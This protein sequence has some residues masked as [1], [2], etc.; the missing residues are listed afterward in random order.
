MT[1]LFKVLVSISERHCNTKLQALK[2]LVLDFNIK[3]S[4]FRY[5]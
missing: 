3:S 1:N 5:I 2:K 4:N